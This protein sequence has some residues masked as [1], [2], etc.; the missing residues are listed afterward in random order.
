MWARGW[1]GAVIAEQ[2]PA[3]PDYSGAALTQVLPSVAAALGENESPAALAL[4]PARRAVVVLVDGLGDELL[5]RYA[6]YAP[7]LRSAR[8]NTGS[9]VLDTV[10]PTTTA[11]ALT[12]LATG[13][14]PAV[15]GMVGY[16]SFDPA[17]R[18]VVNQLGG[19]PGDLDPEAW[20]PNP[21]WLQTLAQRRSVITVSRPKFRSSALTRAGLRGGEFV[22]AK[23]PT[24]RVSLTLQALREHRD[25]LVYLYWDDLDKAGHQHGTA[26]QQWAE[27]L[28]ELDSSLRRLA[29][30]LP[31]DTLLLLTAD[32]GMVDIDRPGRIDYSQDP[33]LVD[34][35][36][37]TA[38]EPRGVQL[39][40]HPS[41]GEA[42]REATVAAWRQAYGEHAWIL[43]GEQI[44]ASGWF[45]PEFA[46]GMRRRVGDVLVAVHGDL[47][48]YDGRRVAPHAMDMVGQHGSLT[49][50]ERRVPLLVMAGA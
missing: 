43:S 27:A 6:G 13:L 50:A 4:P 25:A 1:C 17:G 45:G 42:T 23:T 3:A 32:H 35:V 14:P 46:Q 47:A 37:F 28:E 20:Q 12:S 22:E 29:G 39:H 10:F 11:A 26:S 44:E 41:A 36:E 21:T 30:R 7:T 38:G 5:T 19:W 2:A 24:A 15:T 49:T 16:D 40:F 31:A 9:T 48:L 34:G 33:A 8:A 18:R